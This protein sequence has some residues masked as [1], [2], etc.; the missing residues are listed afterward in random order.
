M[1]DSPV[2]IGAI[3]PFWNDFFA[4]GGFVVGVMGCI[5]GVLGF[6]YTILQVK[7]TKAAAVAA[8]EAAVAVLNERRSV[9]H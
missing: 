3:D 4:A 2:T 9:F 6:W 5:V 8:E 7:K 1:T